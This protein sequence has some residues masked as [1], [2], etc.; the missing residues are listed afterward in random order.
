LR[1]VRSLGHSAR[2]EEMI[3]KVFE[4]EGFTERPRRL[5]PTRTPMLKSGTARRTTGA[6]S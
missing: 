6:R 1:A 2:I 5:E 3:E 4:Q